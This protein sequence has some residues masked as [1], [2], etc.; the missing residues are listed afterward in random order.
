MPRQTRR[1]FLKQAVAGSACATTLA[2]SGAIQASG[3]NDRVTL[4][5]IGCGGQGGRLAEGFSKSANIACVCDPDEANRRRVKAKTGAKQDYDDLRRVLDDKS[6]DAVAVATPDHWHAP[7]AILACDAGKHVYVEKP[8]SHNLLESRLLLDAARRNKVVVQQGTQSRSDPFVADAVQMLHEGIIGDVLVCKA[9]NIQRRA[10]IGH[11][12]PSDPPPGVNYEMWVG[13]AEFVP[14]QK[15]RYHYNWRW[16]HNFGAGDIGNDGT[17][18]IDYA[19]WGLGVTGLPNSAMAT[20]GKYAIDDDQEFPDTAMCIFE[21]PGNGNVGNRRQLIFEMRLWSKNYPFNCDSGAEFYGTAGRMML[22]KRGKLEI[23]DDHNQQIKNAKP[24][25]VRTEVVS[26][27]ADF[28]DAIKTGRKP[29]ADVAIAH[30]TVALVHL[31]NVALKLNRSLQVDPTKEQ[32]IGDKEANALL[33][34][35]YR[36]GGHWA[37]PKGAQS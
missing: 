32:I 9:W 7:A 31:A 18:D 2:W 15:N 17:H 26:H 35:K 10:N 13:P 33:S 27:Q 8:Q 23:Y 30:D 12:Q 19:R 6:I 37:I 25:E 24:E 29:N 20:G 4:G 16:W 1:S 28:L 14:F 34:R 21:W 11:E 5:V 36:E 3:A 22:S